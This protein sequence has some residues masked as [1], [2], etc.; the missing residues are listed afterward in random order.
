VNYSSFLEQTAFTNFLVT[1][2]GAPQFRPDSMTISHDGVLELP[3]I[4]ALQDV[5]G[6]TALLLASIVKY[7]VPVVVEFAPGGSG[8]QL[9][10]TVVV[11]SWSHT[12]TPSRY[13]VT[14]GFEPATFIGV[15]RLNNGDYGILDT[16][17]LAF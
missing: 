14:I 2:F 16:N 8:K 11:S 12:S 17:L 1:N 9:L 6:Y 13:D 10:Q 3:D 5:N 15:F 4:N 7:G